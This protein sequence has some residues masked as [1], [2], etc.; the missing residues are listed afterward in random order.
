MV[1]ETVFIAIVAAV[2][3]A[4]TQFLKRTTQDNPEAFD[5]YKFGATVIIGAGIGA[6]AGSSGRV[7]SEVD[8]E[9][10]LGLYAGATAIIENVLKLAWRVVKKK[11][12]PGL[13][14]EGDGD[15][16]N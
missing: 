15:G 2:M 1:Y 6:V 7:P 3:Y 14:S 8:V 11:V 4:G 5:Y 12:L 16:G 13:F 10:Q 9:L